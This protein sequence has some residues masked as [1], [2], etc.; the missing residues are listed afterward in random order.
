[1]LPIL[2]SQF[3]EDM[4]I[5]NNFIN[6]DSPD[7]TFVELGAMNGITY[8]NTYF[9]ENVLKFNGVL[10]EPSK[11][12]NELLIY[13]PNNK[14]YNLAINYSSEESIFIGHTGA[15]CGLADK[16]TDSFK[17]IHH[18]NHSAEK[19]YYVKC[20]P[21]RDI[22]QDSGLKY[23][24]IFSIDVEGGEKAVLETFDF[25]I[26]VYIIIIELDGHNKEKDQDCREILLKHGFSFNIRVNI[27]EFWV[28]KNYFRKDRLFNKN[29]EKITFD[30]MMD[31][32]NIPY[33]DM[34]HPNIPQ[35]RESLYINNN[36]FE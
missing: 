9:F 14:C 35:L 36:N 4:Y 16:M 22:I 28:N 3:G 1:M 7:G 29:I 18:K 20:S 30:N 31:K 34:N 5:F 23:I 13:R 26:P 27:N 32:A 15:C 21:I 17:S 25:N 8:S 10:I 2:T 11:E 6:V 12:Y 19:E 33:L 24:D